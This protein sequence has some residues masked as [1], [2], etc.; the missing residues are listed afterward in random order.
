MKYGNLLV[1]PISLQLPGSVNLENYWYVV[2]ICFQTYV[3]DTKFEST[4]GFCGHSFCTACLETYVS[5]AIDD[6]PGCLFLRCPDPYCRAVIGE[7][8]VNLLVSDGGKMKYKE[9][10]LLRSYVNN[11]KNIKWC[12]TP[13]CE[14]AIEHELGNESYDVICDCSTSF[15]WNCLE[16]SHGPL[17]CPTMEE[18]TLKNSSESEN[19][20]W[21]LANSKPC[22]KCKVIIEKIN[23]GC[24]HMID[25]SLWLRVLLDMPSG[26]TRIIMSLLTT[27]T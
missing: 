2:Y 11:N 8:M 3:F 22:P 14:C 19:V 4:V 24:K 6:G 23:G 1:Y 7:D 21:I 26:H 9:F 16:D 20:T 5:K 15:C 13:D 12:P 25:L 27:I 17:D 10:F 18:W